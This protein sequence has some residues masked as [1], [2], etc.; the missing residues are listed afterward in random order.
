VT[1]AGAGSLQWLRRR[2]RRSLL[3]LLRDNG[4][5]HRA[6]LARRAG[7]SRATVSTIVA[8]LIAEGVVE[9]ANGARSSRGRAGTPLR[10]CTPGEV[11]VGVEL[12]AAEVTVA[13]VDLSRSPLGDRTSPVPSGRPLETA[14]R[15]GVHLATGML[16]EAGTSWAQVV[17]IGIGARDAGASGAQLL[18]VL[19]GC[20]DAP[21][22]IERP[23]RAAALAEAIWGA[24][25]STM[26][27]VE[28]SAD[29][30]CAVLSGGRLVSGAAGEAGRLGH[31]VVDENGPVCTCGNR[32]CLRLYAGAPA[33][34]ASLRPLLGAGIGVGDVV[35]AAAGGDRAT[36]RVLSDV[37]A[38]VGRVLGGVCN[39]V[40]PERVVLGG[41][42]APAADALLP[43]VRR[44]LRRNALPVTVRDVA[45][46]PNRLGPRAAALGSA[47]L[48]LSRH[49]AEQRIPACT[50]SSS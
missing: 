50:S 43:A 13:L 44:A 35:A 3:A 28:L 38:W 40:N 23:V 11:V 47:A 16:A 25:A 37:G 12:G 22:T 42:L 27:Y 48:A 21:I 41:E 1:T 19:A 20:G 34:L 2:N 14:L 15:A 10:L 32:G 26:V 18:P 6:D 8:E 24:G 46:V 33:I 17:G 9:E 31:T 29:L 30:D 4:E 45:V 39:L 49:A 7:L 36:Q 5:L